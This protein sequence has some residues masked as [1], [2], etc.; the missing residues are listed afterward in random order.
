MKCKRGSV[1]GMTNRKERVM[2]G[3]YDCSTL[4]TRMKLK[5]YTKGR[6][7][8]KTNRGTEYD[9]SILYASLEVHHL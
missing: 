7:I 5:L 4:Y 8:R 2:K 9:Q 3:D 6:E 1:W